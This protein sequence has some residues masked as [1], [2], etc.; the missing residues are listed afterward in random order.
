MDIAA[1]SMA[2]SQANLMTQVNTAVLAMNL[3]SIKE[4]GE[5]ITK[6]MEQSVTPNLGQTIDVTC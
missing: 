5:N 4:M 6:L 1:L 3:S 2:S